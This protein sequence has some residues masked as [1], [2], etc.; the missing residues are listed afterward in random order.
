MNLSENNCSTCFKH[1]K[2]KELTIVIDGNSG[3]AGN[4]CGKCLEKY[5]KLSEDEKV[6]VE[7]VDG[8]TLLYCWR[9]GLKT[10]NN[11]LFLSHECTKTKSTI[12]FAKSLLG[13]RVKN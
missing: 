2:T 3:K 6:G 8:K 9:C 10:E 7:I 5:K 13:G 4:L 1:F 11:D 12:E